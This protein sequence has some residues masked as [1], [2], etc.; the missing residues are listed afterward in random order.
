MVRIETKGTF[1]V[2]V[3]DQVMFQVVEKVVM[4]V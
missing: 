1:K 2:E 4:M 3:V